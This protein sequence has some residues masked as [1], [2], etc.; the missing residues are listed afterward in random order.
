METYD[1]V[2]A[3]VKQVL[4]NLDGQI[5]LS[6]DILRYEKRYYYR[7]DYLCLSAHFIDSNWK[8]KKWVL[9]F[10]RDDD[11]KELPH[12]LLLNAVK[13]WE[14]VGKISAIT[15]LNDTSF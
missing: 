10:R 15:M 1:E 4:S 2:K 9:R 11:M 13:E 8:M 12:E 7:R 14:I 6:I 3:K 5:S